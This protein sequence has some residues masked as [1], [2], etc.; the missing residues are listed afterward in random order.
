MCDLFLQTSKALDLKVRSRQPLE[1]AQS[2]PQV[3]RN[4]IFNVVLEIR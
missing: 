1:I 2:W 4:Y 3:K